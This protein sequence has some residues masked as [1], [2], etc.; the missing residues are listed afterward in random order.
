M[1]IGE[2]ERGLEAAEFWVFGLYGSSARGT[3]LQRW[4]Q[5]LSRLALQEFAAEVFAEQDDS[6]FDVVQG[7]S[8]RW[9]LG[10]VEM[11]KQ[12]FGGGLWDGP[13]MGRN[14]HG[15]SLFFPLELLSTVAQ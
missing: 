4:R 3:G 5:G 1:S 12:V 14:L 6:L 10:S 11:A 7:C 2:A 15:R 13:D 8:P 9:S